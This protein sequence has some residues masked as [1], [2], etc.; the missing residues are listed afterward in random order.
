MAVY[1]EFINLIVPREEIDRCYPGGLQRLLADKHDVMGKTVWMDEHL[2][3]FGAMDEEMI[4]SLQKK[5]QGYGIKKLVV[6]WSP[7]NRETSCDWLEFDIRTQSASLK[8]FLHG[9]LFG[10][11]RRGYSAL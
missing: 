6:I 1:C 8:G 7:I 5:W 3:R 4:N 9:K 10:P 2:V 11:S